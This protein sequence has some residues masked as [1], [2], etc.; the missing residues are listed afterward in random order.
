MKK[1]ESEALIQR[2][3]EIYALHQE[4]EKEGIEMKQ[5]NWF[6][7]EENRSFCLRVVRKDG[8]PTTYIYVIPVK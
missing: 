6:F 4:G 3:N 8:K 2:L 7:D 5:K 1:V